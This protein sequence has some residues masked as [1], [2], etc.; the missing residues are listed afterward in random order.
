MTK[1]F[2]LVTK[3]G[4]FSDKIYHIKMRERK[5]IFFWSKWKWITE[6]YNSGGEYIISKSPQ[7][8]FCQFMDA[9][10]SLKRIQ[11]KTQ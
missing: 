3:S 1:Q 7:G 4:T 2:R 6:I 9:V 10:D 11:S 8:W 5:F